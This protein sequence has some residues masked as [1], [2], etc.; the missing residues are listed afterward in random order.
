MRRDFYVLKGDGGFAPGDEYAHSKAT[1]LAQIGD[2][3]TIEKIVQAFA[4]LDLLGGQ[5]YVQAVRAKFDADGNRIPDEQAKDTHGSWQT[6]GFAFRFETADPA[7]AA[8]KG[9]SFEVKG[10][11]EERPNDDAELANNA[12][13]AQMVSEPVEGSPEPEPASTE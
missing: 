9:K 3:P 11:I 7:L 4:M 12:A 10:L 2:A 6:V 13:A 8:A 5:F 1:A